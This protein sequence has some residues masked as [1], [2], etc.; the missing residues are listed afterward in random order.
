MGLLLRSA[1]LIIELH[2]EPGSLVET[3]PQIRWRFLV[4]SGA[5]NLGG[6][7]AWT[8]PPEE[9]LIHLA[10]HLAAHHRFIDAIPRLLDLTL[11]VRTYGSG[12]DWPAFTNRCAT[13]GI[14]GW[15]ATALGTARAMLGAPIPDE[16]LAA[17]RV[18][19]LDQL[20]TVASEHAWWPYRL[21]EAPG[22]VLSAPTPL[23][24]AARLGH[25][26]VELFRET[27]ASATEPGLGP[28]QL[29]RRLRVTAQFR[30]PAFLRTVWLNVARPAEGERLRR[31]SAENQALFEAMRRQ[32]PGVPR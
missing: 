18:P 32:S 12:I 15:V 7:P 23:A 5:V 21:G 19:D 4:A 31:L 10:L 1:S 14:S 16:V 30:L 9:T 2:R 17:F 22:S 28:R 8:L 27:K 26:L 3:I 6:V 13:L 25:R 29:F 24:R 20:C 11:V